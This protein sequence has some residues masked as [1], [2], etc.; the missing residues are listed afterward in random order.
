MFQ[1]ND[2]INVDNPF[3]DGVDD[4]SDFV[5]QAAIS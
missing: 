5:H 3:N 2:V 1:A 4:F